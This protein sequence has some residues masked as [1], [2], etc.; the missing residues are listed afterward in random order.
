MWKFLLAAMLLLLGI[1]L[2]LSRPVDLEA[3][4]LTEGHGLTHPTAS[5]TIYPRDGAV[6]PRLAKD[7]ATVTKSS[8]SLPEVE[9]ASSAMH[10]GDYIDPDAIT[11]RMPSSSLVQ[12]LGA[13]KDPE[14]IDERSP[15]SEP[16]HLGNYMDPEQPAYISA[17]NGV[18][19]EIGEYIDADALFL[20]FTPQPD[21]TP[22]HLGEEKDPENYL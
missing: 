10:L 20:D 7:T 6:T 19:Q 4:G 12:H 2:Y 15:L 11:E 5:G 3:D 8:R 13:Y 1:S 21:A 17:A 18:L 9:Q 22:R 14:L 16:Q